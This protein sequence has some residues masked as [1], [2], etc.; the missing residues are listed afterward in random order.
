MVPRHDGWVRNYDPG[1]FVTPSSVPELRELILAL[2]KEDGAQL[3][4]RGAQ[5]SDAPSVYT[6]DFDPVRGP[7]SATRVNVL[8]DRLNSFDVDGDVIRAGA[9]MHLGR[10]PYAL[11]PRRGGP[12]VVGRPHRRSGGTGAAPGTFRSS[13]VHRLD[14][15]HLALPELGGISHQTL[16]G[17]LCTGSAGGSTQYDL[18]DSICELTLINGMGRLVTLHR[19]EPDFPVALTSLGL[20]GVIVEVGFSKDPK[21]V[22]QPLPAA[23][24]V[25]MTA[26]TARVDDAPFDLFQDGAVAGFLCGHEYARI[27][28]WPQRD[29]NKVQ[30]WTGAR[31]TCDPSVAP[32]PYVSFDRSTQYVAAWLYR[33]LLPCV[34]PMIASGQPPAE[35]R[36]RARLE[37]LRAVTP[38]P[39]E[40]DDAALMGALSERLATGMRESAVDPSW[41]D[42]LIALL[43]N[44]FVKAEVRTNLLDHW[45]RALPHDNQVDDNVIPILFTESWLDL[46][47][48]HLA[49]RR[50]RD[51][52]AREGLEATGT[53]CLEIYAA[54]NKSSVLSP[55][56]G[57]K[58]VRIDPFVFWVDGRTRD[59]AVQTLF[60]RHW[61]A[62][63]DFGFR[64]HWGKILEP[65]TPEVVAR[66]RAA[67][68][69]E[70]WDRFLST[71]QRYD[72]RGLFLTTYWREHLGL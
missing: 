66:R 21:K 13:L 14:E 33:H 43:L 67:Y 11:R 53:M 9:G 46:D 44:F 5:H 17:F 38:R 55:C 65:A 22:G 30:L 56:C 45:F 71:R 39:P 8:L 2:L 62:L 42:C 34:A 24:D 54:N 68:G 64:S 59:Q 35:P 40:L 58:V 60:A 37:A 63:R 29:V 7:R 3:R 10:D 61:E 50:L 41:R 49:L 52:F 31:V 48:A 6:D 16:G 32:R 69:Q 51:L 36:I 15:M 25:A 26:R 4:V 1:R 70:R 12:D 47:Q 20:L 57:K 28:W 27:L 72:P 19:G 23:Y 18:V